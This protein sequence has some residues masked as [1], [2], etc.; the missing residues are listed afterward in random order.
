MSSQS[1]SRPTWSSR[2]AFILVATGSAVGL[3]NIWKFPYITGENG[4]G[5]FVLVYLC[6][7]ALIGVPVMVAELLIGRQGRLS[8]VNS[9]AKLSRENN[10]SKVWISAG[11]M[12]VI[13][14][15]VIL[16]FYSVVAGWALPYVVYA[17][18][19]FSGYDA[20]A[21][22]SLFTGL[23]KNP[24]ELIIWHSLFM[25]ATVLISALGIH[26]GIERSIQ[27]MIPLLF[28]L[29]A[30]LIGYSLVVNTASFWSAV[31]YLFSPD[32]S[33]LTAA[34]VL[35]ALGHA[36][37]SLSLGVGAMMAY[38]SYTRS[39]TS[40]VQTTY[41][42]AAL[43][44]LVALMAGLAIFPIV[45]ASSLAPETGPGLVFTTLPLAFGKMPYGPFFGGLFFIMLSVAALSSSISLLEVIVQYMEEQGISRAIGALCVGILIWLFGLTTVFSFNIWSDLRPL[46]FIQGFENKGLFDLYNYAT[47]NILIPAAGLLIALFA[48]YV[49]EK[50]RSQTEFG[51]RYSH[52]V[53][54][55][56]IRYVSPICIVLVFIANIVNTEN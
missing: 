35:T 22:G 28:F 25:S 33:K 32:F 14:A 18:Q 16:S 5:A 43:D 49:I 48:G 24:Y 13:S 9:L 20:A 40:I 51:N 12:G 37:F 39:D 31:S 1:F 34:G 15:F 29:L 41:A 38:G 11:L 23:Q 53:W 45:F 30:L 4:G 10:S 6:C 7:I 56:L 55:F 2:T 17:F 54:Y 36:F 52:M 50:K 8:P 3:G 42:I 47:T 27:I 46:S 21:V 19:G 26:S 44:T